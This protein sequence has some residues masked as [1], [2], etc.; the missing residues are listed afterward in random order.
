MGWF[1]W[2]ATGLV[3]PCS[4]ADQ[5]AATQGAECLQFLETFGYN[6]SIG[7]GNLEHLR[8]NKSYSPLASFQGKQ[9]W[10][11][12]YVVCFF[13]I[14]K[15]GNDFLCFRSAGSMGIRM[16]F[17]HFWEVERGCC[18]HWPKHPKWFTA[19]FAADVFFLHVLF[20][21]GWSCEKG[22]LAC[23]YVEKLL[24]NS[25]TDFVRD[26][27]FCS[28]FQLKRIKSH[29]TKRVF[30]TKTLILNAFVVDLFLLVNRSSIPTRV[31][32]EGPCG[33]MLKVMTTW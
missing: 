19:I 27:L 12:L 3:E 24:V 22:C 29:P 25:S 13:S 10:F 7:W 21:P 4:P 18:F 32:V 26:K 9:F 30:W 17:R 16:I 33:T 2:G 1:H 20:S 11:F 6:A 28:K 23:R 14:L 8:T 31:G 5:H 15:S